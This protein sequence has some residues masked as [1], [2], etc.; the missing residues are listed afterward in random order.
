MIEG[1]EHTGDVHKCTVCSCEFTD[2]EDSIVLRMHAGNHDE[3]ELVYEV[4]AWLADCRQR[5]LPLVSK[6]GIGFDIPVLHR[7]AMLQ[8]VREELQGLKR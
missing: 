5:G 3:Y 6:N 1:L 7:R 4:W 8:D 2:D